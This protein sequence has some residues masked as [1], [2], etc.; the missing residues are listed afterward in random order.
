[1]DGTLISGSLPASPL[2]VLLAD[3]AAI[4]RNV[5]KELLA[6]R[7][8]DWFV[9]AESSDGPDVLEKVREF[10]PDVVLL[11][12]SVPKMSGLE[13]AKILQQDHPGTT[14]ILISAQEPAM[15]A[16]IASIAHVRYFI[17]KSVLAK[18]L[19]PL[20]EKISHRGHSGTEATA[21]SPQV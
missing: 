19:V 8:N 16:R 2:R 17:S 10:R 3:D 5:L 20:L 18:H 6:G 15:L 14:I 1:M 21:A 11:D 13:I 4:V 7:P 12:L 9:C